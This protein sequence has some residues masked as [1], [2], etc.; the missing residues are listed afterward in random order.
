M[1]RT[2]FALLLAIPL[3][4]TAQIY[5]TTDQNGNVVY[6]DKPPVT[7]DSAEKVKLNPINTSAPPRE[8]IRPS[9]KEVSE[10]ATA[11]SYS[12]DIVSPANETTVP[13]GPGNFLLSANIEPTP[14]AGETL[15]LQVDGVPWGEPQT[16]A[17]WALTNVFRGAHDLTVSV[18]DKKG[19][20]L[21]TSS[22]I[23]VYVMRPSINNKNRN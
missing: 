22:P 8:V 2:L 10:E 18:L 21:G 3:A 14:G 6:T 15:Q 4:A 16:S 13:M 11:V 12:I 1:T 19:A 9:T 7:G 20:P 17:S 23:R 5:K